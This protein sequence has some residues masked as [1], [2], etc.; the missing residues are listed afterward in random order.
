M[1]RRHPGEIEPGRGHDSH[2]VAD[3]PTGAIGDLLRAQVRRANQIERRLVLLPRAIHPEGGS[4]GHR[5][6]LHDVTHH[7]NPVTVLERQ[8][9]EVGGPQQTEP[10]DRDRHGGAERDN[11]D[12]AHPRRLHRHP[13]GVAQIRPQV[14]E[15]A[16]TPLVA[17]IFPA[18]RDTAEP[19]QRRRPRFARRQSLRSVVFYGPIDVVGQLLVELTIQ[20]VSSEHRSHTQTQDQ[21]PCS[22]TVTRFPQD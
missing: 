17:A 21:P 19:S 14:V 6:R 3:S 16:E 18:L 1:E 13:N 22:R 9:G 7:D 20:L 4:C 2:R 15:P 10:P 5:I 8:V 12:S 11:T